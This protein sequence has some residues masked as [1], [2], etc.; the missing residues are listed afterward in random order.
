MRAY[1]PWQPT[2]GRLNK[3]ITIPGSKSITNR[4]LL[5]AS[6][7]QGV[8]RLEGVL[9]SD[10]SRAALAALTELGI[11]FEVDEAKHIIL[12][13]GCAGHVPVQKASLYFQDAGT[14]TRFI[15]PICAAMPS[16]VYHFSASKRMMER[17]LKP[18]LDKLAEQ[19]C[20]LHYEQNPEGMPLAMEATG[21]RGG[22]VLVDIQ[23]SSQFLSGLLLAAPLAQ[24]PMRLTAS[25]PLEKKPYVAMTVAMMKSFGVYPIVQSEMLI[26]PQNHY[27]SPGSYCI[28]PDAS[29]A[30]YFFAAAALLQGEVTIRGIRRQMLQ[31]DTRFLEVLERMGCGVIEATEG[32]CVVGPDRLKG[33]G[34][35]SM[36]GFSDTF[37]TVAALAA[38]ADS[39][40]T[41]TG[42][43]HT[44]GQE[45][46][47]V[48]CMAEGLRRVGLRVETT[49]D[50]ITIYPGA[51]KGALVDGYNDHRIAMSLALIGLRVPGVTIDGA[52]CVAKTC[53]DYFERLASLFDAG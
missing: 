37:M 26:I 43:A 15:I 30:S 42:L 4:A 21:L 34:I 24:S 45:S 3:T 50:S 33:L 51:M 19:G 44:R 2:L 48:A 36:A 46:D 27:Q 39:P 38:F 40:S 8:T 41:L 23:A 22:H 17:P 52:E 7:A 13:H 49:K 31:G 28:E 53:P 16:G 1:L 29:T 25:E 20:I 5:L 35:C 12:V 9:F 18:L 11:R 32:I 10:D 14:A 6:L 47:R